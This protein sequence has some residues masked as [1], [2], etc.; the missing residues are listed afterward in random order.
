MSQAQGH[1]RPDAL[2]GRF[3]RV[4]VDGLGFPGLATDN[5]AG[6]VFDT[7]TRLGRQAGALIVATFDGRGEERDGQAG[8]HISPLKARLMLI[9]LPAGPSLFFR[10]R[11]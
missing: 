2:L 5:Q 6:P 7:W 9:C 1:A 10:T 4:S 11:T 3:A 8:D